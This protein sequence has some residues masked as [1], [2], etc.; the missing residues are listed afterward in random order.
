MR[1]CILIATVIL[2]LLFLGC[3]EEITEKPLTPV[4][5]PKEE[6]R[7]EVH[8]SYK[9]ETGPEH[10]AE[11]GYSDCAGSEQSPVDIPADAPIHDADISFN[12]N[13]SA[14]NIINNGHTIKVEY[15]KGSTIEVEGKTYNLLQFHFHAP[16]E[17]TING[18]YYDMELHLVHQSDDGEYAVI[19]V[20]IKAGSENDAYTPVWEH[21]PAEKGELETISGVSV[22][23]IDLLPED[24]SYYRYNGS[25]TTPPCTEGVKWFVL[26]TPVELSNE[27]IGAFKAIYSG[28]NRPTQPM[29]EREFI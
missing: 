11:L 20:M 18:E 21:L 10:W 27:Q 19:G 5:T 17:H 8:W 13:P 7:E 12:Y 1:R 6:V 16:S 3:A 9:G 4:E 29:N 28:N 23:A 2:A 25:F 26:S 14:L 15:D 22:N 24:R